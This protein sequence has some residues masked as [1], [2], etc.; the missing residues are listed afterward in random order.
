MVWWKCYFGLKDVLRQ[1]EDERYIVEN[2]I[3]VSIICTTYNQD[4]YI[5]DAI[6]S[7]LMQ[8][9]D[10]SYEIII[11]D[12]AS[13][14]N[15]KKIIKT[16]EKLYPD[17][18]HSIIQTENKYSQG[19]NILENYE[20]PVARGK[21]IAFCE[22][23]DYWT[24]P[25]KLK[26]QVEMLEKHEEC[27]VCAHAASVVRAQDKT[28]IRKIAPSTQ[29]KIFETREVILGDGGFVATNSLMMRKSLFDCIPEFRKEYRIDYSL[30]IWGA[31]RGGMLYLSENMSSYREFAQSS[32][33]NRMRKDISRYVKHY[34]KIIMMLGKLDVFTNQKYSKEISNRIRWQKFQM[35]I[36]Q[37]ENR[38]IISGDY[39]EFLKKMPLKEQCK[40]YVKAACPWLC[41]VNEWRK[42]YVR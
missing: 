18:I 12:D 41:K 9:T 36:I 42:K 24:D 39:S 38:K 3:M 10:F 7:F 17:I 21:Y 25:Y 4:I 6:K 40:I 11:H 26:K 34:E 5:E 37:Q 29:N 16:Y 8:I 30:Q 13:T 1:I 22:G 23:D 14:D 27:D 19:V 28:E 32:W 33:S 31:L 20:L 35:L 2:K 15:T